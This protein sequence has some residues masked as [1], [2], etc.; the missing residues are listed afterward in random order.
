MLRRLLKHL[1]KARDPVAG[2]PAPD[3]KPA[4][5]WEMTPSE[6]SAATV[7]AI[8]ALGYE[9]EA[10][11][12]THGLY[13]ATIPRKGVWIFGAAQKHEIDKHDLTPL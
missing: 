7:Q 2:V 3:F 6:F 11:P 12:G 5:L 1:F 8:R 4:F 10:I 13:R 9:P